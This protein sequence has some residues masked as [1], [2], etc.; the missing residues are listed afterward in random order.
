MTQFCVLVS[1]QSVHGSLAVSRFFE[2]RK[3]TRNM[4]SE[5]GS[6]LR[7]HVNRLFSRVKQNKW[8]FRSRISDMHL[9][10]V[11]RNGFQKWNEMLIFLR[12]KGRPNFHINKVSCNVQFCVG[13]GRGI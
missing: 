4:A 6:T 13:Y 8:K 5:F 9:H 11:M 10:D 1:T 7:V 2:L 12:S 3:L